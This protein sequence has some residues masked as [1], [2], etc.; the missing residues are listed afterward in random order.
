MKPRARRRQIHELTDVASTDVLSN[1]S[2]DTRMRRIVT[3]EHVEQA[4][5]TARR[6]DWRQEITSVAEAGRPYTVVDFTLPG[7]KLIEDR[8]VD[9][10]SYTRDIPTSTNQPAD[11]TVL[12]RNLRPTEPLLKNVEQ[13]SHEVLQLAYSRSMVHVRKWPMFEYDDILRAIQNLPRQFQPVVIVS[14]NIFMRNVTN[15]W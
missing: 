13:L 12:P 10:R 8:F 7:F 9:R 3:E 1:L 2:G 11:L 6:A 4:P 14:I 15:F 5:R